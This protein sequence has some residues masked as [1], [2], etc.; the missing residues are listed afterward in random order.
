[1]TDSSFAPR[2]CF[3]YAA[4]SS[5][6]GAVLVVGTVIWVVLV[7]AL[8]VVVVVTVVAVVVVTGRVVRVVVVARVVVV[9]LDGVSLPIED[10]GSVVGGVDDTVVVTGGPAVVPSGP[11]DIPGVMCSKKSFFSVSGPTDE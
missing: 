10:G 6:T 11:G 9:E 1:M 2:I 8:V 3:G 4:A 7:V 5:P